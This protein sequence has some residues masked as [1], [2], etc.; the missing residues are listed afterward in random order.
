[1]EMRLE[2]S[3]DVEKGLTDLGAASVYGYQLLR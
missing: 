3:K 2:E 1:M